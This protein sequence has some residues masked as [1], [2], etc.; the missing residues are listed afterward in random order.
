MFF[1][2]ELDSFLKLSF[3]F[4]YTAQLA[5]V[6]QFYLYLINIEMEL[7]PSQVCF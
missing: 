2:L 5:I 1:V 6:C 7:I 4:S 3:Q